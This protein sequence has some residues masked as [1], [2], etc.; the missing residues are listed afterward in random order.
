V[1]RGRARTHAKIVRDLERLAR[2]APGGSAERPIVIVS[3]A[4]VEVMA[5][6]QPCPLCRGP[7]R[8]EEHV[9]LTQGGARLRAA[10]VACTAC[11]SRRTLYFALRDGL[12]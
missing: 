6:A 9:A 1:G 3:S 8:V 7:L 4:Q 2:L 11:G 12:H 5:G 10:R